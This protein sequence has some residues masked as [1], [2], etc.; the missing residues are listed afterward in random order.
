MLYKGRFLTNICY[1]W[2][3]SEEI[4]AI[5]GRGPDQYM[6]LKGGVGTNMCYAREGSGPIFAIEKRDPYQYMLY[7]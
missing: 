6:L 5:Q 4:Y 3:G 2:E 1:T 7:T